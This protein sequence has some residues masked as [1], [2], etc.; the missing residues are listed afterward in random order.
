MNLHV[1]FFVKETVINTSYWY[2][3]RRVWLLL[4]VFEDLGGFLVRDNGL[5][6]SGEMTFIFGVCS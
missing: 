4:C 6:R 5:M 3:R 1:F 2:G